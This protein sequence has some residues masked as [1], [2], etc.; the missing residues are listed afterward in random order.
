[1]I[2]LSC[3]FCEKVEWN[4]KD[5]RSGSFYNIQV[6]LPSGRI[7]TV[8]SNKPYEV[9]SKVPFD[10]VVRTSQQGREFLQLIVAK[11]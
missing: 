7:A 11:A 4:S 10:I 1:M 2:T 9:G 5:G 8:Q 6:K 3:V